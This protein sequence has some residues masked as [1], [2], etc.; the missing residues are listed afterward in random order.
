MTA[1]LKTGPTEQALTDAMVERVAEGIKDAIRRALADQNLYCADC[2]KTM[3]MEPTH[4]QAGPPFE[5]P[6]V[7]RVVNWEFKDPKGWV[8]ARGVNG[9]G[10]IRTYCPDCAGKRGI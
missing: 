9:G 8:T 2:R 3:A 6:G 5:M 1:N 10:D 4:L 7:W